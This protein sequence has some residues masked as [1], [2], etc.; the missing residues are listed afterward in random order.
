MSVIVESSFNERDNEN[1]LY[2]EFEGEPF[3][4]ITLGV[5]KIEAIVDGVIVSSDDSKLSFDDEGNVTM[6]LGTSNIPIGS[7]P[8]I[9]V[10]YD[11]LH[12]NGQVIASPSMPRSRVTVKMNKGS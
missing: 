3:K 11:D 1:E 2:F 5:S 7:Y 6:K 8:L 10:I 4:F 9:V 12:P